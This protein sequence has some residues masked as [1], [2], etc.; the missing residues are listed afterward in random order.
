VFCWCGIST[1][2]YV[3]VV[4]DGKHV[5]VEEEVQCVFGR[6]RWRMREGRSCG[7]CVCSSH[8]VAKICDVS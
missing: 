8:C 5:A 6:T 1:G 4:H 7:E 3:W 2:E